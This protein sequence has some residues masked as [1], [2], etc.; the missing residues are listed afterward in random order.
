MTPPPPRRSRRGGALSSTA[1]PAHI[2]QAT[3]LHTTPSLGDSALCRPLPPCP[4]PAAIKPDRVGM[5]SAEGRPIFAQVP[6]HSGDRDSPHN[7][8]AQITAELTAH[9][10]DDEAAAMVVGQIAELCRVRAD[11][12]D[13]ALLLG[14]GTMREG[15]PHHMGGDAVP[16][17]AL[18]V[19]SQRCDD[20]LALRRRTMLE[21]V[22]HDEVAERVPAELRRAL[23]HLARQCLRLPS[24]APL[25][26]ALQDPAAEAV[27]R[28][29]I[30]MPGQLVDHELQHLRSR[31]LGQPLEDM[32][33][34]RRVAS[35]DDSAFHALGHRRQLLGRQQGEG[36]LHDAAAHRRRGQRP[37]VRGDPANGP[38]ALG[39][40]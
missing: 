40:I 27:A 23:Q 17:K 37:H 31:H 12:V 18:D 38:R 26:Q 33:R 28:Y 4:L 14:V 7:P 29:A 16:R 25:E 1:Q 35:L 6:A 22:L 36:F 11:R 2:P 5:T 30:S 3:R 20:G 19:P 13:E 24:G 39:A 10:P 32:V 21:Q 34:V 8:T 9:V 15:R